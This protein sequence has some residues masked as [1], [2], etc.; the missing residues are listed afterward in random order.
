MS[1]FEGHQAREILTFCYVQVLQLIGWG[2][3]PSESDLPHSAH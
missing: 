1:L 2:P 3:P